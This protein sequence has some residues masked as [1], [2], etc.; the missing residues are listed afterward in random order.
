MKLGRRDQGVMRVIVLVDSNM[1]TVETDLVSH[2]L[3][4]YVSRK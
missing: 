2:R 1:I 4:Q 3:D